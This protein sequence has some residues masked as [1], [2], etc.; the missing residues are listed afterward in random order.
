M[1]LVLEFVNEERLKT[2]DQEARRNQVTQLIG[3]QYAYAR[4]G[5]RKRPLA[6]ERRSSLSLR[7][8][9]FYSTTPTISSSRVAG[10]EMKVIPKIHIPHN[11]FDIKRLVRCK[12]IPVLRVHES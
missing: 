1:S 3:W 10:I 4:G 11:Q 12:G 9:N 6:L 7:S 8:R 2:S 5:F